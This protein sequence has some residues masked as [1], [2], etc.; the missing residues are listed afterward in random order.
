MKPSELRIGNLMQEHYTGKIIS[1]IKL[2]EKTITFSG[3]FIGKWQAEKIPLSE[4]ILLKCGFRSNSE[5]EIGHLKFIWYGNDNLGIKGILGLI[6]PNS[7]KY[8]HE[9]QNIVRA[10]CGQE[11]NTSGL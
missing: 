6:K 5:L 9:L 11:L 1:V 2:T 4:E 7:I 8:L 3:S 10:L